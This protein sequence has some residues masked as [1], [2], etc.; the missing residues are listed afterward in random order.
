MKLTILGNNGPYPAEGGTCSGYLLSS[1]RENTRILID[2]G[3]GVLARLSRHCSWDELDAVVLSHLHFDH[4][5][6][7]LPMQYALQFHPRKPLPV[8]APAEP[9]NIRS[10][11]NAPVFDLHRIHASLDLQIGNMRLRFAPT[12]HP[13]ECYAV[14][15]ECEGRVFGYTG[16]SNTLP[17]L[18]DFLS[19]ADVLLADAGLSDADWKETAPH[20]SSRI[21]AELANAAN[22]KH[23]LLTHLNPRYTTEELESEAHTLRPEARCVQ[24]EETLEI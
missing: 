6:D 19:G 11:L 13:V 23:L 22:A 16:D 18:A 8:Y 24:L 1:E 4:M 7:M 10:M 17:E 12:R 9:E 15:V 20:F 5:S 3:T 14:R 2:C 21:C